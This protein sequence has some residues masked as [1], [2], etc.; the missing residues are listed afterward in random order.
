MSAVRV[1]VVG[2]LT[3]L[4]TQYR[5][6]A[7]AGIDVDVTDVDCPSL[8]R[9]AEAADALVLVVGNVSHAAAGK[10]RE[11]AKRRGIPLTPAMGS[12]VSRIRSAVKTASE[13]IAGR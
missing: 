8:E 11:V 9:R 3:R 1:F 5:D 2:G 13:S 4:V 7:P 10:V 6:A 12:S